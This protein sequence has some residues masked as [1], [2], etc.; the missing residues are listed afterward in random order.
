M[1]RRDLIPSWPT[2][3]ECDCAV[4][5][6]RRPHDE[7]ERLVWRVDRLTAWHVGAPGSSERTIEPD[8]D[9]TLADIGAL[10]VFADAI[11]MRADELRSFADQ[12]DAELST[13]DSM[14]LD[15]PL[16]RAAAEARRVRLES[17]GG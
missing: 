5:L 10:W 14:R 2:S 1:P 4:D 9:P 11:R 17:R 7:I 6:L 13:I 12:I 3:D 8:R 15:L 16:Q